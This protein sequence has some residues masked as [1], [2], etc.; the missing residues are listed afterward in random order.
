MFFPAYQ[1]DSFKTE[2]EALKSA[3][4]TSEDLKHS[5]PATVISG[6]IP[7]NCTAKMI[8]GDGVLVFSYNTDGRVSVW[9]SDDYWECPTLADAQEL[10]T[11]IEGGI[12]A[13][14]WATF[15]IMDYKLHAK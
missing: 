1:L 4:M 5:I 7:E 9:F 2:Q 6:D 10:I 12:P 11:S 3:D 15:E 8:A 13:E 14:F